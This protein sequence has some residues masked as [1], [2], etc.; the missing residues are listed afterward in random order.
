MDDQNKEKTLEKR[1]EQLETKVENVKNAQKKK[2]HKL[3]PEEDPPKI[4]GII[5]TSL[6]GQC[7]SFNEI[8]DF[9]KNNNLF[10]LEDGAQSFGATMHKEKSCSLTDIAATVFFLQSLWVVMEMV[11]QFLQMM[12]S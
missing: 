1:M 7:A 2:Q 3:S 6:Y 5:A 11:E 9:A 4:K 10:V 12:M 8:N